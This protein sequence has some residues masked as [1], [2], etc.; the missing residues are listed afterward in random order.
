[1]VA[2]MLNCSLVAVDAQSSTSMTAPGGGADAA[3]GHAAAG[4]GGGDVEAAVHGVGGDV[5]ALRGAAVAGGDARC[6][7]RWCRRRR[8]DT[9]PELLIG[10]TV[11]LLP[12]G[13]MLKT[14]VARPAD[15]FHCCIGEVPQSTTIG[16]PAVKMAERVYW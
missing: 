1:M 12:L 13:A 2:W 10:E 4:A 11:Q 14:E 5:P 3:D 16:L 15:W 6:P 7:C 8:R 9:C